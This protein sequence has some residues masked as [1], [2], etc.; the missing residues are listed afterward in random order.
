[1]KVARQDNIRISLISSDSVIKGEVENSV[2]SPGVII[3][4]KAL[5]RNSIIMKNTVIGK[6]SIIERCILDEEV[7]IGE[8]CLIGFG[9]SLVPGNWDIT[10][11]GKNVTVPGNTAIG[12][13]C[14]IF[15]KVQPSDFAGNVVLSDT[16]V[17]R[18]RTQAVEA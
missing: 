16:S 1:M 4:E 7:K 15:P 17:S 11:L 12:R 2:L 6:H 8:F 5:V 3:E 13:N 18:R 10:V 9:A 14:R